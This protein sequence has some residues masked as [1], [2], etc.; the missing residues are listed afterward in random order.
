MKDTDQ[1]RPLKSKAAPVPPSVLGLC[2]LQAWVK[3]LKAQA[4]GTQVVPP[5][6][7]LGAHCIPFGLSQ[8]LSVLFSVK[9]KRFGKRK[10]TGQDWRVC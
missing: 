3:A 4:A 10:R 6:S 5:T 9:D 8:K 7:R 1:G 2:G